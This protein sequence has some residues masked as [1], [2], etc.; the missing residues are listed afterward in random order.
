M[1][2]CRK[3]AQKNMSFRRRPEDLEKMTSLR[4]GNLPFKASMEVGCSFNNLREGTS[5]DRG[6]KNLLQVNI[7]SAP[8]NIGVR[9]FLD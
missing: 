9:I 5:I 6:G 8:V 3:Y 4:V 1:N 7:C 2:I